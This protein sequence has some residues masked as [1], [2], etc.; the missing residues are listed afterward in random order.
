M[1]LI[2]LNISEYKPG[3]RSSYIPLPDNISGK[4]A[5][6]N[7]ENKYGPKCFMW[8]I[9]RHLHPVEN[10]CVRLTV[11]TQYENDLNFRGIDFPVKLKD[12]KQFEK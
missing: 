2:E 5:I 7:L 10:H 11:L 6:N 4:K 3:K 12:S 8:S 1:K 9:L